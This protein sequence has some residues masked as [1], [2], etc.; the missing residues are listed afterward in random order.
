MLVLAIAGL[1]FIMVFVA[2]PALQRGQRD[3]R[4]KNDV[5]RLA[6][7]IVN[8]QSN[9]GSLAKELSS[10][11]GGLTNTGASCIK[12]AT[13]DDIDALR[14]SNIFGCKIIANYI[15]GEDSGSNTFKDP[16]DT[17]YRL[18]IYKP[19]DAAA[20]ASAAVTPGSTKYPNGLMM[21][22]GTY[23]TFGASSSRPM[24]VIPGTKCDSDSDMKFA[25]ADTPESFT[26]RYRLEGGGIE[27]RDNGFE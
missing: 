8:F 16:D 25:A 20:A 2:L 18:Y 21:L 26:V 12:T 22:S 13:L 4:R 10:V 7:A 5:A 3:T 24:I 15:N 19:Y 17:Y 23:A 27:C 14:S 9:G 1:I 11:N 6:A